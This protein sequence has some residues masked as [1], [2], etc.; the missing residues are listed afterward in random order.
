MGRVLGTLKLRGVQ[1]YQQPATLCLY[2]Y[3]LSENGEAS[4]WR[5][6]D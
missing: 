3:R 4:R 2:N 5:R 1:T 6:C